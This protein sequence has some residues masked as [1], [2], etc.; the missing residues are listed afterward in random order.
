MRKRKIS[1]IICKFMVVLLIITFLAPILGDFKQTAV[2][3]TQDTGSSTGSSSNTS[4]EV[5]KAS[6]KDSLK[7]SD[8]QGEVADSLGLS[9]NQPARYSQ[10][11]EE[12]DKHVNPL[13]ADT[14]FLNRNYQL[15]LS[16][17]TGS[18]A[19]LNDQL[20]VYNNPIGKNAIALSGN[21]ATSMS[22]NAKFF[23]A[24]YKKE[25]GL[26][27][28]GDGKQEVATIG[29]TG[30][31]ETYSIQLYISDFD[32]LSSSSAPTTTSS[33]YT[34]VSGLTTCP[35]DKDN[36]YSTDA[37]KC[38]S[39]DLNKDGIDE[40][41]IASGQ[42]LYIGSATMTKYTELSSKE[43]SYAI[44]DIDALDSNGD[45]YPELL[46]T[47][48][49]KK[50]GTIPT[51]SAKLMIY[52]GTTLTKA[53]YTISLDGFYSA[54][55]DIGDILGDGD[56]TIAIGGLNFI[57]KPEI[58][59]VKYYP[60]T[61]SYS[62]NLAKVYEIT[63]IN[64]SAIK[65]AYD[66]KCASLMTHVDGTAEYVVLGGFIFQY[67]TTDDAFKQQSISNYSEDSDGVSSNSAT[68]SASN[69][70]NANKSKDSTYILQTLVGNFDGNTEGKEQVIMLHYNKWFDKEIVYVTQCYITGTAEKSN[71]M[72][73]SD[74]KQLWKKAKKVSYSYPT[75]CAAD[76]YNH[77]TKM[78]I[79]NDKSSFLYSAP[80]ITAVLGASPYYSEIED[81][82]PALGN[83][84]TTYG[85]STENSSSASNGVIAKVGVLFG[86]E[87]SVGIFSVELF[88]INFEAEVTNTFTVN[89]SSA[90]SI[91][92]DISYTNYYSED[93]VVATVIPYDSYVYEVTSW[94]NATNKY[95]TS[96]VVMNVPYAPM[97][98]IMPVD[99]YNKVASKIPNAPVI[100][101]E[102]LNH[103]IGD[104]RSYPSS[105]ANLS[106]VTNKDVLMAGSNIGDS[107]VGCGIGN[108][109]I[110]QAVTTSKT[111][112]K[113]FDYELELDVKL[114]ITVSDV[115]AGVSAG[116]GYSHGITVSSTKS[117]VRSGSVASVPSSCAQYQFQWALVAY[118]YDLTAGSGTQR[119][120]VINYLCKPQGTDY[121]P[122]V[123]ENLKLSAQSIDSTTLSWDA[124]D[125]A[126]GYKIWRST[127][128]DGDY[129]WLSTING[130]STTTYKDTSIVA[131]KDY[132]YKIQALNN[133]STILTDALT[134]LGLQV[135]EIKINT[136]PKLIY[137]EYD[138]LDLSALK[139][140][141]VLSNNKTCDVAYADF[142][143]Y[144]IT[145]SIDGGIELEANNTGTPITITY[146]D[147]ITVNTNNLTVKAIS[148]YP[149]SLTTNFT[150]GST[151]NATALAAN[152][153]VS[154]DINMENTSATKLSV[155]VTLALYDANGSMIEYSIKSVDIAADGKQSCSCSLSNL[156][157]SDINGYKVK[158]FV[159]D[160]KDLLSSN[161]T[162][163]ADV[164]E[165]S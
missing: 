15:A 160:G 127:S 75:I 95:E 14:V 161:M 41:I 119:C 121:P 164:A 20:N 37:L 22:N 141:L 58:T 48:H 142:A 117:T 99:D 145:T 157:P 86:Y 110:T 70:T 12:I 72:I 105:T 46:L 159:W 39:G 163:L 113:S 101:S 88:K 26:D 42:K 93:A 130:K 28:D 25:V 150:V 50:H 136:Q 148:I 154:A 111:K 83:V 3:A 97:T 53:D 13:G 7:S 156:L 71:I 35:Y 129:T 123:P 36:P 73:N 33:I 131:N 29:Y 165:I 31:N 62:T 134:V 153:K 112:E 87:Y 108:S 94:N 6:A 103:T 56:K 104:P 43:C 138:T 106:N 60:E 109:S 45:G 147:K 34:V 9:S 17:I 76:I 124:T 66:I 135:S 118:N 55:V 64:V 61:E 132:Y 2:A 24:S 133:V 5:D 4:N 79:M 19:Q 162:P 21:I 63:D 90:T 120:T 10:S 144:L 102:V 38:T 114:S 67:S 51:S 89:W 84:D 11:G 47:V 126:S 78:K 57:D 32:T 49:G 107:F 96:K 158:V 146:G 81:L 8:T 54:S 30:T 80:V 92:K 128:E 85:E 69:I 139:V 52:S 23:T 59:Y 91:S 65:S 98:T 152:K 116:V 68:T 125:G 82:Y 1:K 27:V 140:T 149:I 74:L 143:K 155:L 100:D 77:C 18:G 44:D 122:K 137:K 115:T 40:I 151:S 16:Y